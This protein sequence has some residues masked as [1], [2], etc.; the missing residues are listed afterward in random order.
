MADS[1]FN[2]TTASQA[3]WEGGTLTGVGAPSGALALARNPV[4]YRHEFTTLGGWGDVGKAPGTLSIVDGPGYGG[5]VG[6][7]SADEVWWADNAELITLD[8]SKLYEISARVR[9]IDKGATEQCRFYLGVVGVASDGTTIVNRAGEEDQSNQHYFGANQ[10]SL[11]VRST[12]SWRTFRGYFQ[13]SGSPEGNAHHNPT[14]PDTL[15]TDA[16][17]FRPMFILNYTDGD[18]IAEIDY[19]Q[20]REIPDPVNHALGA[21]VTPYEKETHSP[22]SIV[23]DGDLNTDNYISNNNK[24]RAWVVVDLGGLKPIN[25]IGVWH[26]H[27]DSRTYHYPV[28]QVSNGEPVLFHTPTPLL[29]YSTWVIGSTGDQPGFSAN[30]NSEENAIVEG[31]DPFGLPAAIWECRPGSTSNADGGWQASFEGD[32]SQR[33]RFSVFVRKRVSEEGTTY[34]G[35]E[36][37]DQTEK[38]DGTV[39]GNPYFWSG[40]L[41]QLEVWYLMVGILHPAGHSDGDTGKSGVYSMSGNQQITGTDYRWAAG[42]T[43]QEMRAYLYYSTDDTARQDFVYP[44]VDV[45]DGSEP[46]ID[47]LCQAMAWY[48]VRHHNWAGEYAESAKGMWA[49]LE[50]Q[51][52]RYIRDMV[53][54]NTKNE[55]NHWVEIQAYG[56]PDQPGSGLRTHEVELSE[57]GRITSSQVSWQDRSGLMVGNGSCVHIPQV[58]AHSI[59]DEITIEAEICWMGESKD[60]DRGTILTASSSYYFQVCNDGRLA[61]YTYYGESQNGS[62]YFYSSAP[63][64]VGQWHQV[65]FTEDADGLRSLYI[66]GVLDSSEQH[67]AGIHPLLNRPKGLG[68]GRQVSAGGRELL[69]GVRDVRLWDSCLDQADLGA[70]LTGNETGLAGYWPLDEGVG[71][72][73]TD[74]TG[75]SDGTVIAPR[76]LTVD[77]ETN[78]SLDGGGSWQGWKP[79]GNGDSIPDLPLDA[80]GRLV[81]VQCRQTLNAPKAEAT[82]LL[83]SL[84]LSAQGKRALIKVW[85]G[86]QW[87]TANPKVWDGSQYKLADPRVYTDGRWL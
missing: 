79:L 81:R 38:L 13:G 60:N 3:E 30:G 45:M 75:N 37:S 58:P 10:E 57:A 22:A 73:A 86:T 68:I 23:T 2:E 36:N 70:E 29:D 19:V 14:D 12:G 84:T 16:V 43:T 21:E 48:D 55:G 40:D 46:S 64:V 25:Q 26:Y 66:D 31:A 61:C 71:S 67:E 42:A 59:T 72:V 5:K 76:W 74:L 24:R 41:P 11:D 56:E 8:S 80:D 4:I 34:L 32:N 33:L 17:Y 15:H 53:W 39:D 69:A 65:A 50:T 27:G 87:K 28:T 20:I 35:C 54:G 44:R 85:D 18:G 9:Q 52:I 78:V 82:P 62:N 6:Q 83:D 7:T 63:L 51:Y 49:G 47:E 77:V 1:A